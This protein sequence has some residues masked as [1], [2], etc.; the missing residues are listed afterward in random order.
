[1]LL[2]V[3]SLIMV[4]LVTSYNIFYAFQRRITVTGF[5]AL[6]IVSLLS[7]VTGLTMGILSAQAFDY[8]LPFSLAVS[9]GFTVVAGGLLGRVF[10]WHEA[11]YGILIGLLGA[12]LGTVYGLML[13]GTSKVIL[14]T[15][16]AFIILMY[17][18][19]KFIEWQAGKTTRKKNKKS[20]VV[21]PTHNVQIMLSIFV[22]VFLSFIVFRSNTIQVGKIGQ[23]LTQSAVVDEV[24]DLQVATIQVNSAGLS[25]INTDFKSGSMVK[26]IV[27]VK[28][29]AGK[30]L[31]LIS[32]DLQINADL[33]E[34]DNV[35]L[36]NNPQPGIYKLTLEPAMIEGT[37]TIK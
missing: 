23:P 29:N 20:A 12:M 2:N 32:N 30:N 25:P 37:I 14:I 5:P 26:A 21:S 7:A 11:I 36:L 4:A 17:G 31:K 8:N 34:G 35:F 3:G 10:R 1:M 18:L 22:I 28:P 15:D 6:F 9:G 13:F 33:K 19:Q 16:I 27:N 24:N